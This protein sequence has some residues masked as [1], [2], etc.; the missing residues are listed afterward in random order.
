MLQKSQHSDLQTDTRLY[1]LE[2]L[3]S[4]LSQ[5]DG[6]LLAKNVFEPSIGIMGS[7]IFLLLRLCS[8]TKP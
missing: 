5:L 2:D 6:S 8:V 1:V 4:T 3:K 7:V